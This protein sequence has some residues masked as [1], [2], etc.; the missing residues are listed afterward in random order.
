[1]A[2]AAWLIDCAEPHR[3]EIY[4]DFDFAGDHSGRGAAYPGVPVVQDQAERRCY[5]A[6][7]AFVGVRWSISDLDIRTWWPTQV[8][9][10]NHDRGILCAVVATDG[11]ALR[12]SQR[13]T[14]H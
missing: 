13:S 9:W 4:A 10:D 5:D 6:F 11:S 14:R 3:F 1:M 2:R 7:E 8:S 12:G